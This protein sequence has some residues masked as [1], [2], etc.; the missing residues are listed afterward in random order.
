V[1]LMSSDELR[2]LRRL[3]PHVSTRVYL[4]HAAVS[5]LSV[6]VT[7]AM[8]EFLEARS[9][10]TIDDYDRSVDLIR[11][12]KE[13]LA[14]LLGASAGEIAL[15]KNTSEGLNIV[16]NGI[17]WKPGDRVLLNDREFPSN[18]YPFLNLERRGVEVDFARVTDDRLRVGT[19]EE[20]LAPGTRL[21]SVSHVSFASGHRSDLAGLSALRGR[22]D[23]FLCVDAIQSAGVVR[24]DLGETEVDFLAGGGQKFLMSPLGT[25]YLYVRRELQDAITPAF[26][27]WLS[28]KEP[29]DFLHY[30]LAL[31]GD[32]SRYEFAT[33]N[34]VG[35]AGMNAALE[36]FLE[37]GVERIEEHV[38]ALVDLLRER[39]TAPGVGIED[40]TS[41]P[42]GERAAILTFRLPGGEKLVEQLEER[43]I[44]V[45]FREGRVRVSPHFYNTPEEMEILAGEVRRFMKSENRSGDRP[46]AAGQ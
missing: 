2:E 45:S 40:I 8:K 27:S 22:H 3:F 35:I 34:V 42:P 38:G 23:L 26:V 6:R 29:W 1:S 25:G 7:A 19:L 11:R 46:P 17:P 21:V 36:T 9:S 4:N 10:G 12:T 39:L 15:T 37:I 43:R 41:F 5:P 28:V 30:D 18:V 24:I 33:P 31:A 44:T 13:N 14:R 16:A 32:A 20:L